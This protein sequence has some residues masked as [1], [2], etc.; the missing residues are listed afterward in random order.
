MILKTLKTAIFAA[1]S[2]H[3]EL[4]ETIQSFVV[5]VTDWASTPERWL[6]AETPPEIKKI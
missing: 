1:L 6:G 4:L 5:A 3:R 2:L